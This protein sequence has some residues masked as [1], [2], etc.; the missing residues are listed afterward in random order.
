MIRFRCECGQKISVHEKNAGRRGKCPKC[1]KKVLVPPAPSTPESEKIESIPLA[2]DEEP[3]QPEAAPQPPPSAPE[4]PEV[5]DVIEA[6]KPPSEEK[7]PG[8]IRLVED[9]IA[10]RQNMAPAQDEAYDLIEAVDETPPVEE[11]S[12]PSQPPSAQGVSRPPF[13]QT[14]A[15]YDIADI[16]SQTGPKV[17]G[18]TV[19]VCLSC[20]KSVS[21]QA[22]QQFGYYCSAECKKAVQVKTGT[23][24]MVKD[25]E[26]AEAA[27]GLVRTVVFAL[28]GLVVIAIVGSIAYFALPRIFKPVGEIT[29]AFQPSSHI[30][31][32]SSDETGIYLVLDD[33]TL[34]CIDPAT[35]GKRWTVQLEGESV[36]RIAP[37]PASGGV[38]AATTAGIFRVDPA[39]G[40]A[41]ARKILPVEPGKLP[42]N[43]WS[44]EK[45]FVLVG[46]SE[47]TEDEV[48]TTFSE[49]SKTDGYA[50]MQSERV[51]VWGPRDPAPGASYLVALD[52][53][54]GKEL[55][56]KD[57]RNAAVS[58]VATRAGK[59][60]FVTTELDPKQANP[61]VL[62]AVDENTGNEAFQLPLPESY[63]WHFA[64]SKAG[65]V[66]AG[67]NK[68][69]VVN[70]SG[71]TL[72]EM[73]PPGGTLAARAAAL[74]DRLVAKGQNGTLSCF[75]LSANGK[76][77]WSGSV[78]A[79]VFPPAISGD[80][81]LAGGV[82]PGKKPPEVKEASTLTGLYKE[83]AER[84]SSGI[85]VPKPVPNLT[86]F[87][88]KT[89]RVL[90]VAEDVG[91]RCSHDGKS[92]YALWTE[93]RK[94]EGGSDKLFKTYITALNAK[95]GG[96]VWGVGSMGTSR[97]PPLPY[98]GH[99]YV[100]L[101]EISQTMTAS[102]KVAKTY[103]DRLS[104]VEIK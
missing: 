100:H 55:W 8:S 23:S 45:V 80:I 6:A 43:L 90:W 77:L 26:R 12:S 1:G 79:G 97:N 83:T 53:Q 11:P 60:W 41:N 18:S 87:D 54:A 9:T 62:T 57:L 104:K 10:P 51:P 91:G 42:V 52:P 74:G 56:R 17:D 39:G 22:Y 13:D 28:I 84:L 78:G 93:E 29:V 58:D 34:A 2:R 38:I 73:D 61:S 27:A 44:D 88:L 82:P 5:I 36:H 21:I 66:V 35:L 85:L 48:I 14:A 102:G 59:V 37:V 4:K 95:N 20:G 96:K 46:P 50:G 64:Q 16:T 99:L 65:M 31:D 15:S 7:P 49:L 71:G 92:V 70:D 40:S 32:F 67:V 86:C 25:T 24:Q 103:N 30:S 76:P 33:G 19:G 47:M 98:K 3:Q 94:P 75:D 101:F 63:G 68:I 89:G 69:K 81:V 72:F